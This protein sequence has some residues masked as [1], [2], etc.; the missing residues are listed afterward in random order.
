[1]KKRTMNR[2][3]KRETEVTHLRTITTIVVM[4]AARKTKPPNELS[5]MIELR[6]S[7]APYDDDDE[8]TVSSLSTGF[9]TLTS[10]T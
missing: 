2:E 3:V 10:G 5:A 1:M 7:L 9:G 4:R 6:L 8:V